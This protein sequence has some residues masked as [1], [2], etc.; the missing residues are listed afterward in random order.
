MKLTP[1]ASS[2]TTT[3][4]APGFGTGAS[5]IRSS[6]GP[7]GWWTRMAFIGLV[8]VYERA[9]APRPRGELRT[10]QPQESAK[11]FGLHA[12]YRDFGLFLVIH[13]NLVARFEPRDHFTDSV[14]VDEV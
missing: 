13:A 7:P 4:S 1:A 11:P 9:D 14:D 2:F 6:S 12:A 8:Q 3:S 10:L 5:S